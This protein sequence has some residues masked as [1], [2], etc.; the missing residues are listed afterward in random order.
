MQ[1]TKKSKLN[2]KPMFSCGLESAENYSKNII[3][4][5]IVVISKNKRKYC[6]SGGESSRSIH[7]VSPARPPAC[8]STDFSKVLCKYTLCLVKYIIGSS[9]LDNQL[10][11]TYLSDVNVKTLFEVAGKIIPLKFTPKE[12]PVT[13]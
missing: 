9:T 2:D 1:P 3:I 8:S 13:K 6:I 7:E 5:K 4:R 11:C 10:K 12:V